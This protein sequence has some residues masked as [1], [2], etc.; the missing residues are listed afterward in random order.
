M[1][2]KANLEKGDIRD[3]V[4]LVNHFQ[5]EIIS[6]LYVG[7]LAPKE[8]HAQIEMLHKCC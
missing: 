6:V 2:I 4:K 8:L 5:Q 1:L 7:T 3:G